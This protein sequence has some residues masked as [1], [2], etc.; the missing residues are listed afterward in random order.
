MSHC[1]EL[2]KLLRNLCSYHS[3]LSNSYFKHLK[4]SIAFFF[5]SEPILMQTCSFRKSAFFQ[6]CQHCQWDSTY[7]K[8]TVYSAVSLVQPYSKQQTTELTLLH[9]AVEVCGSGSIVMSQ[10]SSDVFVEHTVIFSI[11]LGITYLRYRDNNKSNTPDLITVC[12]HF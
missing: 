9:L 8:K 1:F 12:R 5:G 6:V 7:L 3:L 10:A 4:V 2:G 11:F